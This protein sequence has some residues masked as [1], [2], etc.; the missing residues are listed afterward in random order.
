MSNDACNIPGMQQT[1]FFKVQI[2]TAQEGMGVTI[3]LYCEAPLRQ[4]RARFWCCCCCCCCCFLFFCFV[5]QMRV[6]K[7]AEA[8]QK[9]ILMATL[10]A[11]D[12]LQMDKDGDGKISPLEFLCRTLVKQVS[13]TN[14]DFLSSLW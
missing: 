12:Y 1:A 8:R 14:V 4:R 10:T 6:E 5:L 11:T 3:M 13:P 2:M 7:S 9:R